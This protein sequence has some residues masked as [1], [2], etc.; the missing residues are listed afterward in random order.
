MHIRDFEQD[1]R[2]TLNG[3]TAD[4]LMVGMAEELGEVVQAFKHQE[5]TL[6]VGE[7]CGD[8]IRYIV[9]F[10]VHLGIPTEYALQS[11][12]DKERKRR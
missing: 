10:M 7:E 12:V 5:G 6:R 8:L 4:Q 2:R 3:E 1:C 11:S 9:L